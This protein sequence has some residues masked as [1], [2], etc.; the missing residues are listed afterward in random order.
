MQNAHPPPNAIAR[1][2]KPKPK[3][4]Q[5]Q[6]NQ[7]KPKTQ[8]PKPKTQN[9]NQNTTEQSQNSV[10]CTSSVLV[11]FRFDF[12]SFYTVHLVHTLVLLCFGLLWF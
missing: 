8:N 9:P 10:M 3:P 4:K 5:T 1:K 7:T 11:G 12:I 6:P 2:T